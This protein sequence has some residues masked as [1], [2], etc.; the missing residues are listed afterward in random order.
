MTTLDL[1]IQLLPFLLLSIPFPFMVWF[2]APRFGGN[3]AL[4]LILSLIP[5][6]NLYVMYFVLPY[7]V[8]SALLTKL[9]RIEAKFDAKLT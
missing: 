2:I 9:E 3:R 1:F 4:W 6:V 5:M 7:R 8:Y